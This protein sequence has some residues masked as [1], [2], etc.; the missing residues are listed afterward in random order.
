VG[1]ITY[2]IRAVSRVISAKENANLS[3]ITE[4]YNMKINTQTIRFTV[5]AILAAASVARAEI[6]VQNNDRVGDA[7]TIKT[8][9]KSDAA[10]AADGG[11]N[12]EVTGGSSPIYVSRAFG[13]V[14]GAARA[15]FVLNV[16]NILSVSNSL[17]TGP[18]TSITDVRY[19]EGVTVEDLMSS[20][21]DVNFYRG[22]FNPTGVWT[23]AHG[24]TVWW[25]AK[26]P[27]PSGTQYSATNVTV[28]LH[29]NDVVGVYSNVLGHVWT[30]S[31]ATPYGP[32]TVGINADN[33]RQPNGTSVAQPSS[34]LILLF[35]M[36]SFTVRNASDEN[37]GRDYDSAVV[38]QWEFTMTI[39]IKGMSTNTVVLSKPAPPIP[40]LSA[41][42]RGGR[43][44]ITAESTGD[45]TDRVIQESATLGG[46]NGPAVWNDAG[47]IHSGQSVTNH[48]IG[49][50]NAVFI[51]YKPTN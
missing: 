28:Q 1:L 12:G 3:E 49:D 32:E 13:P 22:D 26:I 37:E 25:T 45:M 38:P 46:P 44:V 17:P 30:F 42:I 19:L 23:G 40:S 9:V 7:V 21:S 10:K 4:K 47:M 36:P 43:L 48:S 20:P 16:V 5:M 35:P 41:S 14:D 2:V 27:A 50:F 6:K 33:S 11:L 8:D 29:G 24:G 31:N 34:D 51:R 18:R 15:A 39:A